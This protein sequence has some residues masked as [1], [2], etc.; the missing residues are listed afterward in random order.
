MSDRPTDPTSPEATA[1]GP[2]AV[3]GPGPDPE[4]TLDEATS[5]LLAALVELERH[6][7]ADGF[8]APP[9]LFAL[10]RTEDLRVAEPGLAE[11]LGLAP[12]AETGLAEAVTAIEQETFDPGVDLVE[13]LSGIE[14]PPSVHGCAL[15][16][17]RSFLPAGADVTLPEDDA[18]AAAAVAEHPQRQDVRVVVGVLRTGQ[19][20][21]VARLPS[22]PE[23]LLGGADL[24]PG[25]VQVL[26]YTLL[27]DAQST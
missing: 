22:H 15:A 27:P 26:A 3:A 23:E 9:R 2:E 1:V 8:D 16:C 10:A 18:G 21:G 4:Q 7:G 13:A 14:W 5:G 20:H 25:L 11:Q 17:V 6:V 12:S 19:H 24:V